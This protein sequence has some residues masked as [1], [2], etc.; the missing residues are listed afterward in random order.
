MI[1]ILCQTDN[2]R[3]VESFDVFRID[4]LTKWINIGTGEWGYALDIGYS[5]IVVWNSTTY[6]NLLDDY[7]SRSGNCTLSIH[8]RIS[9]GK[10]SM[11]KMKVL[12]WKSWTLSTWTLLITRA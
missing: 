10:D 2:F 12:C 4:V 7:L 5:A 8:L 11:L 6:S 9:D 1:S 3:R